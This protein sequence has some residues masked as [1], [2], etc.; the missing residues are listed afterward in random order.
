MNLPIT[1]MHYPYHPYHDPQFLAAC[2]MMR[3]LTG[4][5][6]HELFVGGGYLRDKYFGFEPK[7][8]DF[9]TLNEVPD[10]FQQ[11]PLAVMSGNYMDDKDS[12]D[13]EGNRRRVLSVWDVDG[14]HYPIQLIQLNPDLASNVDEAVSQFA[15]GIQQIY[16]HDD[17]LQVR[18]PFEND[19]DCKTLTVTRCFSVW[20][21]STI[22]GKLDQLKRDKFPDHAIVIPPEYQELFE[23]A[24]GGEGA[25]L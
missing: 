8:I 25:E 16:W 11:S 10:I 18:E 14:G 17:V 2:D 19:R 13:S 9:F 15:L 12:I 24:Q 21:A 7:D 20:E 22:I 23:K 5:Q 6:P 1:A 4:F 3:R